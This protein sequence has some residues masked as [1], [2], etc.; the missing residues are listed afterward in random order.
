VIAITL[1]T[2]SLFAKIDA[3]DQRFFDLDGEKNVSA[4]ELLNTIQSAA[5]ITLAVD[6][7]PD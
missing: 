1:F 2:A 3:R 7:R 6:R 5:G 4:Q